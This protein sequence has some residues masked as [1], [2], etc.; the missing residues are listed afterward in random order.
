M[1]GNID[2]RIVVLIAEW[3]LLS[4]HLFVSVA[5][6]EVERLVLLVEILLEEL[7]GQVS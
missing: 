2:G 7:L 1:N 6:L 5:I 4:V 3:A